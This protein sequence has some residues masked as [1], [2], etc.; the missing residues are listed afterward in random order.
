MKMMKLLLGILASLFVLTACSLTG[1]AQSISSGT[2]IGT[3]MDQSG[4]VVP[5]ATIELRNDL[6]RYLQTATTDSSGS[7]RFNNV[8][9]NPYVLT[10][11]LSGFKT[12]T[13]SV[14]IRSTIPDEVKLTMAVGG[15]SESVT[16][17]AAAAVIENVPTAHSDMD[18][19]ALMTLASTMIGSGLSE[20]ITMATPGV[21]ADSNGF[22]HPLGDHA[23]TSFQIDGQP[24][25]DQI[26]KVFSTQIPTNAVQSLELNTGF[27]PAEYGEKTS[28]IVNAVTRSGLG[29]AKP[30]GNVVVP[31]GSF[32]SVG[33]EATLGFGGPK[34]GFFTAVNGSRADRFLDTP[35]FQAIH[36]YGNNGSV[37][38]RLDAQPSTA[39]ALHLNVFVARN[40]FQ[41]P[42]SLDQLSQD[43][44]QNVVSFNIAP[45]YQ[46][47]VS[48]HAVLTVNGWVRHDRVNY[49][50]STNIFDDTP[51]TVSQNRGLTSLGMK[52]DVSYAGGVHTVKMGGQFMQTRLE[53]HFGLGITDA[54]FNPVCL[55][56]TGAPVTNPNLV[57]PIACAKASYQPNDGLQPG[58]V[59]IDLT[60][61]GSLFNFYDTANIN[62][63]AGYIQD[64]INW[65]NLTL[66]P[67]LRVT[68][69]DG[70]SQAT[71]VQPRFGVSYLAGKNTVL[72]ASYARTLE[73]PHNENLLVSSATGTGGL[74]DVFGAFGQQPIESGRRNQFNVGIQQT[75]GHVVQVDVDYWVKHTK[76]AAEFDVLLNT[77]ITFPIMWSQ[78]K[79]DG[80]GARI[81]TLN[82]KG[83]RLNTTLGTGRLRYFGP[84]VGGLIFNSPLARV[85]RTDSDDKFYQTTILDYHTTNNGPWAA[86]TW[87][88]DNGEVAGAVA[89]LDNA[90]GLTAAQ[91]SAIG[92]FCG[93]DV[94]TPTHQITGCS[95]PFPNYG[96]KLV[97]IPAPGTANEDTNPP[98]MTPRNLFDVIVGT[99]NLLMTSGKNRVTLQFTVVNLTNKE[100]LYN[101]LSTFGGTHFVQPRTYQAKIGFSF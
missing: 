10:A 37:F 80:F 60:R 51:V 81:S 31:F 79:L 23:E 35:E 85:F 29:L 2:I 45:G 57:D 39:N 50:P 13:Q 54:T 46:H 70:L 30:S 76:N 63:Y 55:T 77:P 61:G 101:F 98:R 62:E 95:Q 88:Y 43:Q 100:A 42:N 49:Y 1:F 67:G 14:A 32:G 73:T 82:L 83:F 99:D 34:F 8:P 40:S 94:A 4:A 93:G 33:T 12:V 44:N 3:V 5:G 26:S 75:F 19:T 65:G 36:D 20:A 71:G 22:F 90:L 48:D 78:N 64:T 58:L 11:T 89:T 86:F 66:S 9:F 47:I 52:G 69:Y 91:Q 72:R 18:A 17:Q 38:L 6:T 41:I 96:A 68:R 24:I 74:T 21:V 59:P 87:R 7:F 53:E 28:L 56:A 97:R 16:V 15:V 92:F 27:P 25:N 84:E